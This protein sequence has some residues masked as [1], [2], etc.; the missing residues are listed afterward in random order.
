M[1]LAPE[2][3]APLKKG[4]GPDNALLSVAVLSICG[5]VMQG[6]TTEVVWSEMVFHSKGIT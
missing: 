1:I 3:K 5:Q 2:C 4:K 6:S